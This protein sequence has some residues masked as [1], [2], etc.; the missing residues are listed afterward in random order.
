MQEKGYYSFNRDG[1]EIY[2]TAD[3]LQ[4][5]K[6]VPLTMD[7][8]KDTLKTP[9]KQYTIGKVEIQYLEKLTDTANVDVKEFENAIIKRIDDQYKVKALWRP[10]TL[11]KG[12]IYNQKNLDLTKRNFLAL[13]NFSI[14]SYKASPDKYSNPN[15]T[16]IN[17]KYKLIPLPKYNFKTAL[18]LHYSQILNLGFSPS[19]E[20][21]ARNI[22]GGAE[23]FTGSVSG[24][25]GTVFDEKNPNALLDRKSTRLNS[26]H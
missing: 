20:L 24:T 23:N 11:K 2:F 21:T 5:R 9:Y 25:F 3:A 8:L 6:Q 13:N 10:I 16:F 22:F 1:G 19:A 12:E 18:D 15:D 17:V 14:A 7:I 4:S 26:S